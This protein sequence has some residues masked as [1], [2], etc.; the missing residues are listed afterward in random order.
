MKIEIIT[1]IMLAM[2]ILN[3]SANVT[4]AIPKSSTSGEFADSPN[5]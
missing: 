4:F 1:P 5:S 3:I 2:F